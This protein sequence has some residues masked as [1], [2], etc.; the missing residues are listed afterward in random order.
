MAPADQAGENAGA[1]PSANDATVVESWR[2][3][4]EEEG[5]DLASAA[6]ATD[7]GATLNLTDLS[8]LADLTAEEAIAQLLPAQVRATVQVPGS[9][10]NADADAPATTITSES[11]IYDS[12]NPDS[13]RNAASGETQE[14]ALDVVWTATSYDNPA[15]NGATFAAQLPEGYQLAD[16]APWW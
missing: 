6:E 7:E 5:Y 11:H 10:N 13:D 1:M 8:A 4:T 2:L 3:P 14:I 9:A 15:T 12:A 16:G